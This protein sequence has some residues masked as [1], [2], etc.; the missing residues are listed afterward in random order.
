[1]AHARTTSARAAMLLVSALGT[2]LL[3]ATTSVM[4]QEADDAK[5]L[6]G[7]FIELYRQGK[8]EEAIPL[9]EKALEI[10][11]RLLDGDKADVSQNLN[12]VAA[13]LANLGELFRSTGRFDKAEPLLL[14]AADIKK[15]LSG[16]D[17]DYSHVLNILA[18]LYNDMGRYDKAEPIFLEAAEIRRSILGLDHPDYATILN[19]LAL[20]YRNTGRYDKAEQ[21]YLQSIEITRKRGSETHAHA[22]TLN[23][24][25]LLYSITGRYDKAEPLYLQASEII[26]KVAGADHPDYAM[27]LNNL[28]LKT[29]MLNTT[30]LLVTLITSSP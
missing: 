15:K 22:T 1:M 6:D 14:R 4:A 9:A 17:V 5:Q 18:L 30:S 25:G 16:P 20:L 13:S 12:D 11:L 29:I 24:L 23:N 28:A 8:Y 3:L 10:R 19:N 2:V 21:L 26:K 27:S 7:Q